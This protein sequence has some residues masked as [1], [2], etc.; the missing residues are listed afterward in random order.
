MGVG[1]RFPS[2]EVWLVCME[3]CPQPC[4]FYLGNLEKRPDVPGNLKATIHKALN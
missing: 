4:D 2:P 3:Q 1:G